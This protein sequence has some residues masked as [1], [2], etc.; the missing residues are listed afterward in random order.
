MS[1]PMT[2]SAEF[3]GAMGNPRVRCAAKNNVGMRDQLQL[4][5]ERGEIRADVVLDLVI[6]ALI[7]TALARITLLDHPVDHSYGARLVDLLRDGAATV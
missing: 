2:W 5:Q 7:G 3:A 1:Q 4:A 6:D